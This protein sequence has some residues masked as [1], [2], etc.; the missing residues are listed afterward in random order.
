MGSLPTSVEWAGHGRDI[1]AVVYG[2]ACSAY[3]PRAAQS[4][5]A[6]SANA[7]SADPVPPRILSGGITT[8]NS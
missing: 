8:A 5:R 4:S 6:T 7:R 2:A 1:E 3:V